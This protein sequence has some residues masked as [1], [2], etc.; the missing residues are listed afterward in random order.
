MF[1]INLQVCAVLE[2][3]KETMLQLSKGTA[4]IL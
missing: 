2:K 3:S 1:K 4:Q